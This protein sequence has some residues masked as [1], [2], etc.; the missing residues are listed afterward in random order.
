MDKWH[1][2]PWNNKGKVREP[3]LLEHF[4]NST[5]ETQ[6]QILIREAIQN[7]LDAAIRVNKIRQ[8]PVKVRIYVSGKSAALSPSKAQKWFGEIFPHLKA[9]KKPL[10]NAPLENEPCS[11]LTFEDFNTRGLF[12]AYDRNYAEDGEDNAWVYFFHKEGDTSKQESDRGRWGIGKVVFPGSSRI[13]TFIG[14]TV[15]EDGKKLLMGQAMLHSRNLNQ[16]RYLP[17]VWLCAPPHPD[18]PWMPIETTSLIKDFCNDF[19]LDR[20]SET[21]FSIVIPYVEQGNKDSD[22]LGIT[23]ETIQDSVIADYFLAILRGDLVVTLASPERTSVIEKE[24]LET[25]VKK[26]QSKLITKRN[27]EINLAIWATRSDVEHVP[28]GLH[29]DD[30][31]V[32]WENSMITNELR[33]TLKQKLQSYDPIAIRVPVQIRTKSGNATNSHFDVYMKLSDNLQGRRPMFI[34]EGLI[35]PDIKVSSLPSKVRALVI[36]QDGGIASLLGD[37]ENPAHTEW[38]SKSSNFKD[39]YFYGPSYL[40]FVIESAGEISRMLLNNEEE[41]NPDLLLDIFSLPTEIEE[42]TK[43]RRRTKPNGN[44]TSTAPKPPKGRPVLLRIEKWGSGFLIRSHSENSPT[45]QR[46]SVRVAYDVR[47]K[48]PF[49]SWSP[50]DFKLSDMASSAE[51]A[52]PIG[53]DGN[54]MLFEIKGHDFKLTFEGFD[55]RRDLKI[56]ARVEGETHEE[57]N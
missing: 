44:E 6:S 7:S 35:I 30:N 54:R 40:R 14:F 8:R 27:D 17:D 45:P 19:H 13:H 51:Q 1:S 3:S 47:N 16:E 41:E 31:S 49:A 20:S 5:F 10:R 15:R 11:F 57:H 26:S 21:G 18:K 23:F 33:E 39:K 50:A 43:K 56:E 29:S 9:L 46:V 32:K 42:E 24:S 25:L 38:Q 36:A 55:P 37:S 22:D 34:R 53:L 12:G 2:T 28:I 48:D 4:A 52:D